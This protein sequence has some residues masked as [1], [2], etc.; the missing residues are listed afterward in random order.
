MLTGKS[1]RSAVSVNLRLASKPSG[2][3]VWFT[4]DPLTLALGPF[5]W[6]GNSPGKALPDVGARLARHTKGNAEGTKSARPGHRVLPRGAFRAVGSVGELVDL[7]FGAPPAPPPDVSDDQV[8]LLHRHLARSEPQGGPSWLAAVRTGRF[9]AIPETLG[10][11][12]SVE[13][14]HLVDGYGMVGELGLG[15]AFAFE[16]AQLSSAQASGKWEG[17]SAQLWATLFLEHRRWRMSGTG[18]DAEAE[19]LLDGLCIQLRAALLATV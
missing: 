18:P 15:D 8:A 5:Q 4:Y 2:C 10:W 19:Q 12:T 7:L 17:G 13:F 11:Q 9:E 16:W 14:A 3:L 1:K 6:F